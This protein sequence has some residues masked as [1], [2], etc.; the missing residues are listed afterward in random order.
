MNPI[1][2]RLLC[3]AAAGRTRRFEQPELSFGRSADN[4]VVVQ[5]SHASRH[6][7]RLRWTGEAWVVENASPN[8]TSVNHRNTGNKPV[9]LK[10]GDVIS[11]GN[12]KLFDVRI[13]PAPDGPAADAAPTP[14]TE[15]PQPDAFAP[16]P[17]QAAR[18]RQ[19]FGLWFGIIGC[20]VGVIL[21]MF[22]F[23]KPLST[24]DQSS[25]PRTAGELT[26]EQIRTEITQPVDA[27]R[28]M[29]EAESHLK[30]AR[31]EY[32]RSITQPDSDALYQ[33]Y[34]NY[35]LAYAKSDGELL[36]EGLTF[37][38]FKRCEQELVD[39]VI[40]LY[41]TGYN[42]LGAGQWNQAARTFRRLTE[43]YRD[44]QSRIFR[45]VTAQLRIAQT[46]ARR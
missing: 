38:E 28:Q 32:Q 19:N 21:L 30:Q 34:R 13:E 36:Q 40:E 25:G 45:N 44:T 24:G 3:G 18:T 9:T 22:A 16:P 5:A 26:T 7:G 43:V 4:H 37:R 12:E 10:S 2:I 33:A 46:R 15:Q 17:D 27:P 20:L 11:V 39:R 31:R 23:V 35:K 1:Q 8:G 42:Q 6:H 29:R 14:P 41:Q